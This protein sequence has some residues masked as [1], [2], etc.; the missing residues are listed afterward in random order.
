M[1]SFETPHT[2]EEV[3]LNKQLQEA[4]SLVSRSL[5]LSLLLGAIQKNGLNLPEVLSALQRIM[6]AHSLTLSRVSGA[7]GEASSIDTV[8]WREGQ[9]PTMSQHAIDLADYQAFCTAPRSV[10]NALEELAPNEMEMG[11]LFW[12]N[13][14]QSFVVY[15]V[16]FQGAPVAALHVSSKKPHAYSFQD[17]AFV[18]MLAEGLAPLLAC[19]HLQE[20]RNRIAEQQTVLSNVQNDYQQQLAE[21][22]RQQEELLTEFKL[23]RQELD[24][25]FKAQQHEL[26]EQVKTALEQAQTANKKLQASQKER[27][28]LNQELQRYR[29]D[30]SQ[31]RNL[32]ERFDSEAHR[33][34]AAGEEMRQYLL[35]LHEVAQTVQ[36]QFDQL[37]QE[38]ESIRRQQAELVMNAASEMIPQARNIANHLESLQDPALGQ[39]QSR[40]LRSVRASIRSGRYLDRLLAQLNDYS[41]CIT[42]QINLNPEPLDI[43]ALAKEIHGQFLSHANNK[44]LQWQLQIPHALSFE[45]DAYT[46]RQL[47]Y[48]LF[49]HTVDATPENGQITVSL[50]QAG[51][52]GGGLTLGLTHTSDP[53]PEEELPHLF[54]PFR[55]PDFD[56]DDDIPPGLSL[57]LVEQFARVQQ[58]QCRVKQAQGQL[59]FVIE[60]PTKVSPLLHTREAAVQK[61]ELP[62]IPNSYL[63][64]FEEAHGFPEV[65]EFQ[66]SMDQLSAPIEF[67]DEFSNPLGSLSDGEDDIDLDESLEEMDGVELTGEDMLDV[68]EQPLPPP[69]APIP[70]PSAVP[71]SVSSGSNPSLKNLAMRSNVGASLAATTTPESPTFRQP[72]P[73]LPTPPLRTPSSPSLNLPPVLAPSSTALTPPPPLTP[74]SALPASKP[75][76][77]IMSPP[78]LPAAPAPVRGLPPLPS[79]LAAE[80]EEEIV[81]AS[82]LILEEIPDEPLPKGS[83][84]SAKGSTSPLSLLTDEGEYT[85]A[86]DK[87]Y[88][89][90]EVTPPTLL[91]LASH[92]EEPQDTIFEDFESNGFQL[93]LAAMDPH[94]L[95]GVPE[96]QRPTVLILYSS[97]VGETYRGI[98]DHMTQQP[99]TTSLPILTTVTTGTQENNFQLN[100]HGLQSQAAPESF[101]RRWFQTLSAHHLGTEYHL[102]SI[103][104]DPA[105]LDT[106]SLM[107]FLGGARYHHHAELNPAQGIQYL[108]KNPPQILLIRLATEQITQWIPMLKEIARSPR[109]QDIPV[110]L[111]SEKPLT[112][113]TKEALSPLQYLYFQPR[114]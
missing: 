73:P 105:T 52:S 92:D 86:V 58:G 100:W 45:G 54:E 90:A 84:V 33:V 87:S 44:K 65:P 23:Q 1:Q 111:L 7:T 63:I 48:A 109:T 39:L 108:W 11:R 97:R 40:Q 55:R 57:P 14:T 88:V 101:W 96:E 93:A 80:E 25:Q 62:A 9:P 82:G 61:I 74:P 36:Q 4:S 79:R 68:A 28:R 94:I 107:L 66:A 47:L 72:I 71:S 81:E 85:P 43:A 64:P 31:L 24:E 56:P 15:P 50:N 34:V 26:L 91:C 113:A 69:P 106:H 67:E 32:T 78:S 13:G 10:G 37:Q 29:E 89:S 95:D 8:T 110:L 19:Y 3:S 104:L 76:Q 35:H 22:Q 2:T 16:L 18:Q 59:H 114:S 112:E 30:R 53:V 38:K 77:A 83:A 98:L 102:L 42:G 20:D 70:V 17:L 12:P 21:A 103:G 99:T 46:T 49:E 51:A 5:E 60:L 6:P 41:R 75:P 27:Q